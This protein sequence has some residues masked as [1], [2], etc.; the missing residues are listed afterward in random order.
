MDVAAGVDVERF[1]VIGEDGVEV[2]EADP[3]RHQR[4]SRIPQ[5][6]VRD[7]GHRGVLLHAQGGPKISEPYQA[8]PGLG[9]PP[10]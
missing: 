5:E 9:K 2:L 1:R 8:S 4:A 3:V 7:D 6:W 10:C